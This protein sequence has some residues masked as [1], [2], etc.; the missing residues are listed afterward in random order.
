[1]NRRTLCKPEQCHFQRQ[2]ITALILLVT[3]LTSACQDP[4]FPDAVQGFLLTGLPKRY[5]QEG[6]VTLRDGDELKVNYKVPFQSPPN[7]AVVDIKQSWFKEKPFNR[8]DFKLL[9]QEATYFK[10]ENDHPEQAC[11]AFATIKWRAE[12]IRAEEAHSK[13]QQQNGG[14]RQPKTTTT[15]NPVP[16]TNPSQPG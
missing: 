4:H 13:S 11:G 15:P 9:Q 7:L 12:G 8:G 16:G 1:M 3:L 10:V 6:E 5:V 2:G 14:N